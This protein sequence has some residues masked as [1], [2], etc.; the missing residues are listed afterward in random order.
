[1]TTLCVFM[2]VPNK[3]ICKFKTV[4]YIIE[5]HSIHGNRDELIT[6]SAR[7]TIFSILAIL[8]RSSRLSI[9]TIST[10]YK[11]QLECA[12]LVTNTKNELSVKEKKKRK[13]K[14]IRREEKRREEKRREE[15]SPSLPPQTKKP[16]N[17][18]DSE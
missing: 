13:E 6:L 14:K 4:R 9:S 3:G 16:F 5:Q 15:N 10:C 17:V 1:M 12:V 18:D 2:S 11:Y 8:T 7:I